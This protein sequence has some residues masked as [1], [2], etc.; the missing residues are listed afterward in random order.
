MSSKLEIDELLQFVV[1]EA[2]DLL[3]TSSCSILLPDEETG[4]M[5]F[6]AAIDP[7]VGMRV[8]LGEG[9]VSNVFR[10]GVPQM[11]ND[12]ATDP[13]YYPKIEQN[14]GRPVR[15]LLAVPLLVEKKVI[16]VLEAINKRGGFFTKGDQDLLMTIAGYTA[17]VIE[18]ARL[19]K[20]IQNHASSLEQLVAERTKELQKLYEKVQ[21]LSVTDDLTGVFNRRGLYHLG[22]REIIRARRFRHHLA[23]I[24]FDLDLFK[25]INDKHGHRIGDQVLRVIARLCSREIREVDIIGRYGGE[26]FVILMPETPIDDAL[27]TAERLRQCIEQQSILTDKGEISTTISLGVS[28]IKDETENITALI[29]KAD[30]AMYLAKQAGRNCIKR[31]E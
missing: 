3:S 18:N 27:Q 11:V 13:D 26:E 6:H 23:A 25:Q 10:T 5:V 21:R 24:L 14:S 28:G 15:S 16:G 2:A 20:S 9:I 7:I 30:A 22:E 17:I 8:P 4:D 29:D 31:I 1:D 19:Y 12:L